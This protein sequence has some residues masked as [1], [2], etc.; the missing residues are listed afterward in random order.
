MNAAGHPLQRVRPQPPQRTGKG[1]KAGVLAAA[2]GSW[3][4]GG[5]HDDGLPITQ[6]CRRPIRLSRCA[7]AGP[8]GCAALGS[9]NS[10]LAWSL[11][12]GPHWRTARR[13]CN[14]WW[15]RSATAGQPTMA[16]A[17]ARLGLH[18]GLRHIAAEARQVGETFPLACELGGPARRGRPRPPV[19]CGTG[20]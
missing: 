19:R 11:P 2:S 7:P 3:S 18:P 17:M 8:L 16:K 10:C 1:R 14:S 12:L 9:G 6:G 20:L 4:A 5:Q 15:P 13:C